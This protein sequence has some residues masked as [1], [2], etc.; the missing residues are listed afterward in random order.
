ML[1]P[2]VKDTFPFSWV[3]RLYKVFDFLFGRGHIQ[4]EWNDNPKTISYYQKK[5]QGLRHHLWLFLI[6]ETSFKDKINNSF[7]QNMFMQLSVNKL[8][9]SLC[10]ELDEKFVMYQQTT[11]SGTIFHS[12][13]KG[14]FSPPLYQILGHNIPETEITTEH[15]NYVKVRSRYYIDE[16]EEAEEAEKTAPNRV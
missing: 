6:T 11:A 9:K 14:S 3:F 10:L 12:V 7:T 16:I 1:P 5:Q 13:A 15:L 4:D 2:W 8:R